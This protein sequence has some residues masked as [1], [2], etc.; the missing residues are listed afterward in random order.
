M[1]SKIYSAV[2][3]GVTAAPRAGSRCVEYQ[4]EP[5][6]VGMSEPPS[7]THECGGVSLCAGSDVGPEPESSYWWP[8]PWV[9]KP[10]IISKRGKRG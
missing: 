1:L 7:W 3:C 4:Q 2:T 10:I 9:P 5:G 6:Q 8:I